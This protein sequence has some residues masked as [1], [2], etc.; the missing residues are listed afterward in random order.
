MS[1]YIIMNTILRVLIFIPLFIFPALAEINEFL[2]LENLSLLNNE[3]LQSIREDVRL[4]L[5]TIKSKRPADALPELKFFQ[6][7]ITKEDTFW[8]IIAKSSLDIDTL[9]SVNGLSTPRD[10]TAGKIIYIPNMRGIIVKTSDMKPVYEILKNSEVREEY[11][12]RVNKINGF[13]K[14]YIFI[15][16]GKLSN[17][18]RS[19][20]LGTCFMFPLNDGRRTSG[21]GSR[22]NPFDRRSLEFHTGVDIACQTFSKVYAARK[23]KVAFSGFKDGYGRLVIIRHEFGYNS[24]YG[25]LSRALVKEG[26]EVNT[27]D[28]I[29]L[30]GNTG[31]T[32]GPH[33]HFEVRKEDRPVNPGLLIKR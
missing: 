7:K 3:K 23:G 8:N 27:G 18:E 1:C 19:L 33:L 14:E 29:A 24:Y 12:F 15:P 30:S 4:S 21:F 13:D 2:A 11:V 17:L 9:M 20:F 10:I 22:K 6:Y 26:D 25:H 31:R 32:T 5:Y 28:F 16:S